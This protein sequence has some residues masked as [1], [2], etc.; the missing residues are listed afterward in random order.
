L[1]RPEQIEKSGF[2]SVTL[3]ELYQRSDYISVHVPKLKRN[4]RP[5]EQGGLRK[6][7][8]GVM[9]MNCARGG[10]VN[11]DDLQAAIKSGKVAGA[12]LDVFEIEPPGECRLFELDRIICTPHLGASTQ[13]AQ[14]NVAVAVA[15]QIIDYLIN[16]TIVNAVNVPSVTGDL[17]TK[18]RSLHGGGR[19]DGVFAGPVGRRTGQNGDHRIYRR[20]QRDGYG[21]GIHGDPQGAAHAHGQTCGQLRQRPGGGQRDGH[22]SY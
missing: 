1:W 14:T 18:N 10:I 16:G 5:V 8:D 3:D 22:Q 20:F 19:S 13:E 11:E 17:L 6:M 7:K 2:E 12:A 4:H 9:I 15:R 21:S